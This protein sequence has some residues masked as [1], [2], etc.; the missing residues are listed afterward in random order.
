VTAAPAPRP[1]RPLLAMA[2]RL[3]AVL[4]LSIMFVTGRIA[5]D[6]GVNLIETAFYRQLIALPVVSLA[7]PPQ[8]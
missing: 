6:H 8:G 4:C 2:L 5:A 3:V 1:H 7:V